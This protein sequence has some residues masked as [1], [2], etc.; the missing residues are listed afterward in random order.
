[1]ALRLILHSSFFLFQKLH[2][3]P[4]LGTFRHT[5]S[6]SRRRTLINPDC[7]FFTCSQARGPDMEIKNADP[8]NFHP[9][10]PTRTPKLHD[11]AQQRLLL[12]NN[13][14]VQTEL[15]FMLMALYIY[16]FPYSQISLA[17]ML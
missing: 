11:S 9:Q 12:I 4:N 7:P 3:Q 15:I 10:P 1:M 14:S 5:M 17:E 6:Y 2:I 13:L 16:R 8:I